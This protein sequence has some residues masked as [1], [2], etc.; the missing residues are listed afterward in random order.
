[1]VEWTAVSTVGYRKSDN[2][3]METVYSELKGGN[4]P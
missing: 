2:W 4:L 3:I 1:M